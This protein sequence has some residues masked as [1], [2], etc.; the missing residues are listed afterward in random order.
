[1]ALS[2]ERL[3]DPPILQGKIVR[4]LK[5]ELFSSSATVHS[6][7]AKNCSNTFQNSREVFQN[8]KASGMHELSLWGGRG[9]SEHRKVTFLNYNSLKS[10]TNTLAGDQFGRNHSKK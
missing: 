6:D 2:P 9:E 3:P 7:Y 8:V 10:P 1:M 4:D 5:K